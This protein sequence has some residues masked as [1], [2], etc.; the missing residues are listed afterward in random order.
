MYLLCC[1][2]AHA[3]CVQMDAL[4]AESE[5][6][7]QL[8]ETIMLHILSLLPAVQQAYSARRVCRAARDRFKHITTVSA[9][10]PDLPLAALQV[11]FQHHAAGMYRQWDLAAARAECGDLPGLQHLHDSGCACDIRVCSFAA[12]ARHLPV[13]QWARS[14][15]PPCP[16]NKS[17]CGSAAAN[18]H[19]H[20]LQVHY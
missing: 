18:G 19:L 12:K 15:S 4:A 5:A 17:T 8:P 6:L 10:S 7:P 20:I 9:C 2:T 11:F 3:S 1:P 14:R 13:L 16:W